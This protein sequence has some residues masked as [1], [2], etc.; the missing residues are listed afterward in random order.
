MPK[1]TS[2]VQLITCTCCWSFDALTTYHVNPLFS[3]FTATKIWDSFKQER[4]SN[5]WPYIERL[6]MGYSEQMQPHL[7]CDLFLK[8]ESSTSG[9]F[10]VV[11]Y[12]RSVPA[13]VITVKTNTKQAVSLLVTYQIR[14]EL[15][16]LTC[17]AC[18][19]PIVCSFI[20]FERTTVYFFF[21]LSF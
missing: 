5:N 19:Q 8:M 7:Q 4:F 2:E 15:S 14:C 17:K 13:H 3:H 20:Q 18:H 9:H 6:Q 1:R 16:I 21:L 10:P 12:F 11:C